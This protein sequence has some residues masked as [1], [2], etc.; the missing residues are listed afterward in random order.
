M[1]TAL[2]S[3][4]IGLVRPL[5]ALIHKSFQIPFHSKSSCSTK[6]NDIVKAVQGETAFVWINISLKFRLRC[7]VCHKKQTNSRLW[8]RRLV[9]YGGNSKQLEVLV[10]VKCPGRHFVSV[11]LPKACDGDD[12]W[13]GLALSLGLWWKMVAW[14][15][16]MLSLAQC[17]HPTRL[18]QAKPINF[19]A[20]K[21]LEQGSFITLH[22]CKTAFSLIIP[23]MTVLH[24]Q[25]DCWIRY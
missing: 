19:V 2:Q 10:M 22:C 15:W 6:I 4:A 11:S 7:C 20:K 17:V 9:S 8:V 23:K 25:D 18:S 16:S 3:C 12:V 5:L 1:I 13:L 21:F 14:F 24:L